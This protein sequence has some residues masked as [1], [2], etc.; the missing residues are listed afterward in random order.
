MLDARLSTQA[1]WDAPALLLTV[2]AE[3]LVGRSID[4]R[5]RQARRLAEVGRADAAMRLY[6]AVT[7]DIAAS[8]ALVRWWGG[9][10]P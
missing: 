5:M 1:A 6:R 7:N 10:A 3:W 9:F 4:F 8:H 2:A